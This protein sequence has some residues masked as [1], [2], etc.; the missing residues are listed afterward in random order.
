AIPGANAL[1]FYSVT[2]VF[3]LQI[4][5]YK[6]GIP[7]NM[8][9][10]HRNPPCRRRN[11]FTNKDVLGSVFWFYGVGSRKKSRRGVHD[12]RMSGMDNEMDAPS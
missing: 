4:E 12:R 10:V 7:F 6:D 11:P 8:K 2:P 3:I 1:L 5:R 9:A